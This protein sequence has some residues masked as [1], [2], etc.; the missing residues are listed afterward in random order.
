MKDHSSS[1]NGAG[2]DFAREDAEHDGS[3][4]S[5]TDRRSESSESLESERNH[6]Y[7]A[8]SYARNPKSRAAK[9]RARATWAAKKVPKKKTIQKSKVTDRANYAGL[10]RMPPG[11]Y[12]KVKAMAAHSVNPINLFYCLY[13]GCDQVFEKSTNLILHY[14]RHCNMRPFKC[15]ICN[16]SFTQSG[17]LTRH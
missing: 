6:D 8:D 3:N 1:L 10:Q 11:S 5:L 4:H 16:Q 9:E 12:K 2:S 17:T 15:T 14:W 13:K 7:K